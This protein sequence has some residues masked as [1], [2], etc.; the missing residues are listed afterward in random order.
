MTLIDIVAL[1]SDS[2]RVT[3]CDEDDDT[4]R[5]ADITLEWQPAE[6]D[7]GISAGW[8]ADGDAPEAVLSAAAAWASER[9]RDD[10]DD[11][12]ED[13]RVAW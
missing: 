6:R 11:Y 4:E 8:L 7:V 1:D 3:W 13:D 10:Y 5:T 2:V 12:D 9:A